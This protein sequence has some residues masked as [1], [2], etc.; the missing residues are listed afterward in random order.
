MKILI[1]SSNLIGDTILSTGIVDYFKNNNK[2]SKFTF[3]IGPTASQIYKNFPALERIIVIKKR[4]FNL[5]WFDMYIKCKKTKWDIIID[6]RS[7]LL[8]YLLKTKKRFIFKKDKKY[9]HIDQLN[10]YFKIQNTSL[11]IYT[12][13]EEEDIVKKDLS[14]NNKYV[15]I[16]PGGNWTPKIWSSK[17]YNDLIKKISNKFN[18]I[19]FI[20]VGSQSEK[21]RYY[22]EITKNIDENYF[23]DLFGKSIT[24]TSAYMKKSNLFIGNDSGLMHLSFASGLKTISLFGPT[25]DKIYGHSKNDCFVIRTKETFGDFNKMD[26]NPKKSYMNSI[27]SNKVLDLIIE[28]KLL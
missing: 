6:L 27:E 12:N 11:N 23:I 18:N 19:K 15:V 25:N 21:D 2:N 1:I 28:N 7:S 22:R 24:L 26:I 17:M 5:H 13:K 8:S 9:H 20:L 10:K 14:L 16:F 4:K 3:I